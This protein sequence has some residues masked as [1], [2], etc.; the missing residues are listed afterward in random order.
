M[1]HSKEQ[2]IQDKDATNKKKFIHLNT[3]LDFVYFVLYNFPLGIVDKHEA[4]DQQVGRNNQLI[5][6]LA[7]TNKCWELTSFEFGIS[8]C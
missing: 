4:T 5:F 7:H 1:L 8:L 6:L 3:V 2:A